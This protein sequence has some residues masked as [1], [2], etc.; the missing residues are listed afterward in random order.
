MMISENDLFG[1]VLVSTF[2][3]YFSVAATA[4]VLKSKSK[5]IPVTGLGSL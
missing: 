3:N 4:V 2:L 5:A 1:Q